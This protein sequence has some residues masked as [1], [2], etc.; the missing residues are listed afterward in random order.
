MSEP[1]RIPG[2]VDPHVHLRGLEWS[3]KATFATETAAALAGGYWAV[4]DMPNTP[5]STIDR[6]ALDTKLAA[7]HTEAVC[8]WG[9]YFGASQQDNSALYGSI[10]D[11]VCGIKIYNN[12]TT[13]T[14][15]IE[16]QALRART[17][18]MWPAGKVIAVHAEGPTVA[19]ILELVRRYRKHTHFCHIS[20]AEEINYLRGAKAEGLPISIGVTPHHLVLTEDD[21]ATLGAF[22][23]M[24]PE[25]KTQADV[26]ALWDAVRHGLVD[27][28][29]SD[30]APHTLAEKAAEV[31]PSGVPGLETT[32]PLLVTAVHEGRLTVEQVVDFVALNPQRIFGLTPPADTYTIVDLAASYEIKRE[33]L[34]TRC[35]WSP[36]EGMRVFGKVREVWIRGQQVF[37]GEHV[38]VE[39]G[40]GRNLYGRK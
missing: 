7:L 8:D 19:Q 13:G 10:I 29:E 15:L 2:M 1:I 5:P 32:L 3:H 37:D 35:G 22:G 14:L 27:V 20:T 36:F 4:L 11:P 24:K 39:S 40:F 34:H 9:V 31:P 6:P 23:R 12:A 28:I 18:A 17:Y 21:V 26:D 38:L 16:D 30:H 33:D 25:L